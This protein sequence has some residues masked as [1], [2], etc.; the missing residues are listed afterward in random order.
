MAALA[1][2]PLARL[3]QSLVRTARKSLPAADVAARLREAFEELPEQ[4]HV[5]VRRSA[6]SRVQKRVAT[7]DRDCV[8]TAGRRR[9]EWSQAPCRAGS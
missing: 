5:T 3:A 1:A 7:D 8:A 2:R 6:S 9:G 4:S